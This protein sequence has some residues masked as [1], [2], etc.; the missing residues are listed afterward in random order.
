MTQTPTNSTPEQLFNDLD[1]VPNRTDL[2]PSFAN[3]KSFIF[4]FDRSGSMWEDIDVAESEVGAFLQAL[5]EFGVRTGLI[6][7]YSDDIRTIAG[8]DEP[9]TDRAE[10]FYTGETDG[11]TPLSDAMISARKMADNTTDDVAIVVF[12]DGYPNDIE[13]YLEVV[14]NTAYPVLGATLLSTGDMNDVPDW[15]QRQANSYTANTVIDTP[16]NLS[17]VLET[18]LRETFESDTR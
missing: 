13:R 15:V 8:L 4:I 6:D 11:P 3:G 5:E 10:D 9:F 16:E 17:L 1:I 14:A 2:N 7:M 12:S 18:L